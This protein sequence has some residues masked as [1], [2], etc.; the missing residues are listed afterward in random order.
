MRIDGMELIGVGAASLVLYLFA[1]DWLV[2]V[3]ILTLWMCL[4]LTATGDRLY[5]LPLAATFQWSQT[6][7]GVFYEGLLGRKVPTIDLSDYRPMVLIG[8]GCVLALS[9]GI[10][11]GLMTRKPPDPAQP[12]PD[13]AFSFGPLIIAY[14][15]SVFVEGTLLAIAPNY[16]SLRQIITTLDTVRLGVLFLIMRRLCSPTPRWAT[17]A[18]VLSVEIMMG[19]TGFFAGFREPIVLAF[20]AVL[21]V[22]DRRNKQH[23]GAVTV[24]IV[25]VGVLGLVWMGI[26]RDYRR[27]YVEID[28]FSNSRS[29]RVQRVSDLTSAFFKNDATEV[30]QTADAL[31]DRMWT[32]YYPALAIAR[33]PSA[34][35]HTH[36]AILNDALTHIVTPRVFFPD[37][38]ELMSDSEKVRKYSNMRV[39]G[40]ESNTSIAFG[41]AAE[42]Y[43]DFGIPV[44][45]VPVFCFG[46]FLGVMYAFFR[47][48]IWHREL[49][50]AFGTVAFWLS[51]YLFERSWATMLGVTMGFM[52]YLGPPTVLLDRFLLVRFAREQAAGGQ[53]V[54]FET[55]L[56]QIGPSD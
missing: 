51:A 44:M 35:P 39:A 6:S 53:Q 23:W 11:A 4:K 14:V 5:V 55:P 28:Q 21:E 16:P 40:R 3:S 49:F 52:V 24:A 7:L 33:V 13:F 2:P 48:I 27:E 31:V 54:M 47:S 37:K 50:V 19:I 20:L 12:R 56:N 1:G 45:F 34:L 41:Y 22:F 30:W 17:L 38:P 8:L 9:A 15:G 32:V 46:L 29:T 26:R 42:A 18:M 25:G 10:K 43:I 36:G